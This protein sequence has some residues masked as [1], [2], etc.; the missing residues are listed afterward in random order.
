MNI[1]FRCSQLHRLMGNTRSIDDSL[2]ND[3]IVQMKKHC[4]LVRKRKKIEDYE[5]EFIQ[6]FDLEVD[7]L[8]KQTLS[9]TAKSLVKEI[10]RGI[11]HGAPTKFAGSRET[12][13]GNMV[14]EDAIRFLMQQEFISVEKNTIR[15]TNDWITGEPDIVGR[16]IQDAKCPWNYWTM[17]YFADDIESKSLDA[18][19]DWQ[20]LGYMWLLRENNE[21]DPVIIDIAE[22][23]FI[24]MPT[25]LSLLRKYDDVYLH[26]QFVL[27]LPAKDR[28]STYPVK[29]DQEKVELIK[30]KVEAARKY[31][32]TLKLGG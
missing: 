6:I 23:K 25:P 26:T 7:K 20:Q 13:K 4:D 11:K 16:K 22:L 29:Y 9:A 8:Q 31:A 17:E 12:E 5:L 21:Y 15:Y 14:E 3:Y 32:A 18:G 19:Y 2:M 1:I 28:I 24:L 10:V 27:D 30:I